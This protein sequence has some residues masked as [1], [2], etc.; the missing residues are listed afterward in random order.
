MTMAQAVASV[1]SFVIVWAVARGM[2]DAA[3]GI[4]ASAYA[5]ATS[6]AA[7][8]DSG[9]RMALIRETARFPKQ[10]RR[11]L[12]YALVISVS[13]AF[14]VGLGFVGTV[15]FE[16]ALASQELRFWLLGYAML[17]TL[18]RITL[19]IPAGYQRLVSVAVWGAFERVMS[20]VLVAGLV[21]FW[22]VSLIELAQAMC[23]L[24]LSVL[25]CL[26]IWIFWLGWPTEPNV[27]VTMPAFIKVAI[28]FGV[29]AAAFAVLG[30]LDLIVLGFQQPAA[31]IGHY[32][33]AQLL[34][35]I[36]V[37]IG[38]SISGALFPTLSQL[39]KTE[40][41]EQSKRLLQP[42]LGL[43]MLV[44]VML[45]IVISTLSWWLLSYVYG[46]NYVSGSGWLIL[47]ALVAPFAAVNSIA[48]AVIGARGWQKRWATFLWKLL[49]VAAG[50]YWLMGSFI[51][52]WGVAW[53]NVGVQI[54]LTLVAW[55]W[56]SDAG[57]VHMSW[58]LRLTGLIGVN[59]L[60]FW[61]LP[62]SL[63]L[64]TIPITLVGI[65]LLGICTLDWVKMA[66]KVVR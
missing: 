25:L 64:I 62:E 37:F 45:A 18:M 54:V 32:A 20:A 51:G 53:V 6:I 48:G 40:D 15:L 55:K 56:M 57:V 3:Y 36:G 35:M 65:F 52:I 2:G 23:V 31:T 21:F 41:V 29:S 16:E 42:A 17:W 49:P 19:G 46:S 12:S 22:Q 1:A 28:P 34:A 4:F 27:E 58:L 13:L 39:G 66:F 33:A 11:L 9:V 30:R 7:L 26:A 50:M 10:W 43:L 14:V 38:V 63:F 47:F 8:T 60:M 59:G 24:E 44:M 5:L 61:M